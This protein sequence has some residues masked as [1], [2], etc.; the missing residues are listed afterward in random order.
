[1]NYP[2]LKISRYS[3]ILEETFF[4]A[5]NQILR[6]RLAMLKKKE[7]NIQT[8]SN[9]SGIKNN[10]VLQQLVDLDIRPEILAALCLIPIIEVAWAD[11]SVDKKERDAILKGA[12][13]T[14]FSADEDILNE[15]LQTK[16]DPKLMEAWEIYMQGLCEIIDDEA[17]SLLKDEIISHTQS[18]AEASGGFLGLI[19]TVSNSEKKMIEKIKGFFAKPG[20][21]YIDIK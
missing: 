12:K 4:F 16:P 5:E 13:K 9:I 20:T 17:I 6:D 19:N 11:G 7:E 15:W 1:M 8:L 14:Y 10:L 2:D 3:K 18:V 21:C